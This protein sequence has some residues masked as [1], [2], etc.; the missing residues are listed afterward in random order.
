MELGTG[1]GIAGILIG[2]LIAVIQ[3]RSPNISVECKLNPNND[4]DCIECIVLNRGLAEAKDVYVGFNNMLLL[5]TTIFSRPELGLELIEANLPPDPNA[6]PHVAHLTKAFSVRIPRVA[7]KSEINFQIKTID[8]DNLRA[9]GQVLRIREEI[10]N[11]LTAF[12]ER[13]SA[14]HSEEYS[15]WNAPSIIQGRIKQENFFSPGKFSYIKGEFLVEFFS[16]DEKL[17]LAANQ[18]LYSKYKKEN[19]DVFSAGKKFKAPVLRIRTPSGESTYAIFPPYVN[20]SVE[21]IAS[22]KEIKE[23]GGVSISPP[24]PETYD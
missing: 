18:D 3:G 11:V 19:I 7:K 23:K 12:G 9:A 24:V 20:T 5:G 14:H 22:R 1:I 15:K 4:P 6:F 10:I 17:A 13:L 21:I 16:Y 2:I 8:K